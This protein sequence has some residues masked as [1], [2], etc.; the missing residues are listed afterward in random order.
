MSTSKAEINL[1]ED[2]LYIVQDG[3]KIKIS[4]KQHGTDTI[5]YKNGKIL[6]IERSE[7]VRIGDQETI[8]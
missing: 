5:I 4:P 8:K 3:K 1:R 7:R 2:A 6:D